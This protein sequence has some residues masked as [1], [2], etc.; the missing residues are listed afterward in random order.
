MCENSAAVRDH[1]LQQ[2]CD[3]GDG[4]NKNISL[5][6][7][8]A[9]AA[10]ELSQEPGDRRTIY[11]VITALAS[12]VIILAT[13]CFVYILRLSRGRGGALLCSLPC[14]S[15]YTEVESKSCDTVS[16]TTIQ[17]NR[18]NLE[19]KDISQFIK[20]ILKR[21][22][23]KNIFTP[24]DLMTMTCSGSGSGLPLLLQRT[25]ARQVLLREC[26]GKGRFGEVRRGVWR[27]SNVAVKIFSSLDE[28][29]WVREVE[30]YQTSMLRHDNILGFIAA[31]NKDDGTCT[32]LWLITHYMEKGSLYDYLTL[33]TVTAD[34]VNSF[35]SY[36]QHSSYIFFN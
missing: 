19:T 29:S 10:V 24:Q 16:T 8:S 22:F 17:V 2:C 20:N 5:V 11:L 25:V 18:V 33:H 1:Y 15:Q 30:V 32:Q 34:Q 13:G 6:F 14:V 23:L 35:A 21:R 3:K 4:C 9:E 7:S 36:C 26:I 27:G 12:L 31:D 28:K